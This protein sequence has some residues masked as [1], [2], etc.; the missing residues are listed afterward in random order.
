M[1]GTRRRPSRSSTSTGKSLGLLSQPTIGSANLSA[2]EDRTEAYLNFASFNYPPTIFRV[3]LATPGAA[4]KYWSGPEV[5][6]DPATTEVTQVWYPSKDGTKISMFLT[7][8]KGMARKGDAPV[9]LSGYGAFNVQPGS[10]VCRA[11]SPLVRSRAAS[12][13][14]PTSAAAANTAKRGIRPACSARRR[15]AWT[16]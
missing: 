8:K 13:P 7:H 5:P 1:S 12:S 4:P 11:V 6:V 10:H 9:M 3:D 14:C 2:S 15:T 16:I